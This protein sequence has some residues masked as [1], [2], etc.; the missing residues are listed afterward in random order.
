M[1]NWL[2]ENKDDVQYEMKRW[3]S[4]TMLCDVT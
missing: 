3:E 2:K 4:N 1:F